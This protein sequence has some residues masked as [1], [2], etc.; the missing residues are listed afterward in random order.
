M[1]SLAFVHRNDTRFAIGDFSPVLSVFSYHELGSTVSPFLLLDHL[2]PG[3]LVPGRPRGGVHEHPHRGFETVTI[4]YAGELEHRD[5]SGGGGLIGPGDVQWMTAAH[6]VVHRELFSEAFAQTG[7]RFE[8]VQLWV[9]LPAAHKMDA[10]RYQNLSA[11]RI[12]VVA[13]PCDEPCDGSGEA[14]SVRVIAGRFGDSE[15]PALT[16]TR[17]NV[18]DV[19]LAAGQ[20]VRFETRALDTA[21]VYLRSG[22]LDFSP[23]EI[24]NDMQEER[25]EE[26]LEE[27]ALA[28]LSSNEAGFEVRALESSCF[29]V[30]SGERIDE[31]INGHGPFVMNSYDEILQAYDDIKS[32]RFEHPGSE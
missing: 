16:H 17:M 8:L 31:P 4:V 1:K 28:V 14:G 20:R 15:G 29:V 27:N 3:R 2:G 30:L 23:Q 9:N 12:P 24:Q 21:L 13:L 22:R 10:P 25:P 32:G 7:G 11:A 6:G 26:T 5:S 18:L 19:Q